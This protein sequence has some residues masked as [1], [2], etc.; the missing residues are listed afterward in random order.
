MSKLSPKE[1][2]F[3]ESAALLSRMAVEAPA[4][5]KFIVGDSLR[6]TPL[7]YHVARTTADEVKTLQHFVADPSAGRLPRS[8]EQV[9]IIAVHGKPFA[10]RL[11][12]DIHARL[13]VAWALGNALLVAQIPRHVVDPHVPDFR[14]GSRVGLG[15]L[16]IAPVIVTPDRELWTPDDGSF[17]AVDRVD[18]IAD[19]PQNVPIF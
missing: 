12:Q 4:I 7:R 2:L 1:K 19:V 11:A 5:G 15:E 14:F 16:A 6:V 18:H 3:A 17:Y 10:D 9:G 8:Y 13:G